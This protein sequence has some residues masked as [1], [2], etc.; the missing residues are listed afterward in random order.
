[1]NNQFAEVDDEG[2]V[3][4]AEPGETAIVARFERTF[5]ATGVVVL[6]GE[7]GFSPA[8]VP[9]HLVDGPVVE[10]LNRLKIAPSPAAGDEGVLRRV[11]LDLIGVQPRPDEVLV[12]LAET[13]PN[14]RE[15]AIDAQF[16][17]PEFVDHWS[18]KWGDLL[19]NS[20]N[21]V[22]QQSVYLF[23]EFIRSSVAE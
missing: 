20:R 22:S 21:V 16:E 8:P 11:Y 2:R 14:K 10:K 9:Q 3:V 23:R 15:K 5:A 13:D 19:Q 6:K 7:S 18:L 12:F 1:N 17:R 4:A